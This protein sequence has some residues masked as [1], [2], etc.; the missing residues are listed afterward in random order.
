[1]P[2]E[3]KVLTPQQRAQWME[4]GW[5][6]IESAVPK[7]HIE[8]WTKDVWI[9]L[10]MDPND[11]STWTQEK[12]HLPA[13]KQMPM[14]QF[15]PKAWA[16]ACELCGGEDKIDQSLFSMV[17]DSLIC[18]LGDPTDNDE[19]VHPRNTRNWHIDGDWF[20][21]HLDSGDGAMTVIVFYNDVVPRGGGTWVS[22]E[23]MKHVVKWL[24]DH[25][26]GSDGWPEDELGSRSVCNIGAV[27]DFEEMHGK[28][29]DC[30]LFHPFM[31]HSASKNYLRIPRF[32]TNPPIVLKEPFNLNRENWDDYSLLEQKIL[33]D[34]GRTSLPEW[35]RT[36][37][38]K[39]FI[40]HTRAGKDARL[41]EEL[42]R[43]EAHALKTGGELDSMHKDGIVPYLVVTPRVVA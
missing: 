31:P 36:T 3:F 25:P 6:K 7:E 30:I 39:R 5:V 38:R 8:R 35:K 20:T 40:P 4:R 28:A 32:I 43:L 12:I 10:N 18:N 37:P 26:E 24:Y 9:R 13:H 33:K 27:T 14:K 2:Q 22:P 1:M 42:Q 21:H 11:K 29:G 16:A 17:T 15:A 34:L 23:A 41:K 19:E